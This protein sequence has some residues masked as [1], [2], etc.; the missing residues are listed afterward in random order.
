MMLI[1]STES[2]FSQQY[3]LNMLGLEADAKRNEDSVYQEFKEQSGCGK[4]GWCKSNIFWRANSP[5]FPFIKV[6]S[7]ARLRNLSKKLRKNPGLL[8]QDDQIL[9]DQINAGVVKV[10]SYSKLYG[11]DFYLPH[12]HVT[13][14][15]AE[16]TRIRTGFEASGRVNYC[17][18][19]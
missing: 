7:L 15:T 11:K 8:K 16:C 10:V 6:G 12:R 1:S 18:K 5:G 3:S 13:G 2:D 9:S 17:R 19:V 14:E 4:E